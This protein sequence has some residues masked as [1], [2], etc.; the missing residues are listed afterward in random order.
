MPTIYLNQNDRFTDHQRAVDELIAPP[1]QN[2][3]GRAWLE[4][5]EPIGTG[6][7]QLHPDRV[8][9]GRSIFLAPEVHFVRL[10]MQVSAQ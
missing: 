10:S 4:R 1:P 5:E 9:A 6:N 8:H 2:L 3:L 7:R